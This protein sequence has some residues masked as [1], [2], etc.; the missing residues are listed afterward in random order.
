V[1]NFKRYLFQIL[2]LS[3][4][5]LGAAT[6]HGFSF[7][8]CQ[9]S[10]VQAAQWIPSEDEGLFKV[11]LGDP[12]ML[13][14]SQGTCSTIG[15]LDNAADVMVIGFALTGTPATWEA[16]GLGAASSGA[17]A[18]PLAVTAMVAGVGL[19]TIKLAV[20]VTKDECM[21]QQIDARIKK[22]L[23]VYLRQQMKPSF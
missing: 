18:V 19:A 14:L 23:P 11:A 9:V 5:M 15:A 7:E 16:I 1:L 12:Q 17:I 22:A 2:T 4:L 10:A 8:G 3:T 20:L 6:S 21:D 13:A